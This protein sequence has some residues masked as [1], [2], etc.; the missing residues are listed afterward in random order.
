MQE[1]SDLLYE[2]NPR[3]RT[4]YVQGSCVTVLVC[5]FPVSALQDA[6]TGQTDFLLRFSIVLITSWR[7][8][9]SGENSVSM[10]IA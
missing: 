5:L 3:W 2:R 9:H 4:V 1:I 10:R 7:A 8:E 6:G